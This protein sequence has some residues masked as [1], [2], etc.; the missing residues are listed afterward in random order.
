MELEKSPERAD[1]FAWQAFIVLPEC[2]T[3]DLFPYC[4]VCVCVFVLNADHG[5]VGVKLIFFARQKENQKEKR[6]K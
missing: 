6:K 5:Y 4:R 3:I 1:A 2:K